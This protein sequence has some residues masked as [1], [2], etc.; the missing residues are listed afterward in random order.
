[1]ESWKVIEAMF[2]ATD[3]NVLRQWRDAG[4]PPVTLTLRTA[5]GAQSE[6]LLAY[7]ESLATHLPAVTIKRRSAD[8]ETD[9]PALVITER[10]HYLATPMG[11]ELAPF[12]KALLDSGRGLPS[13]TS[14]TARGLSA[15]PLPARLE[16]FITPQ[17]PFCPVT[18]ST[19]LPLALA[20]GRQR[21]S[22]IDGT[23]FPD[24]A[25]ARAIRTAPTVILDGSF[26]WTG[27]PGIDEI[28][29]VMVNREPSRLSPDSLRG[30]IEDGMAETVARMMI[31]HG[32]IFDNLLP[33]LAHDKWPVRLGAMVVMESFQTLRPDLAAEA[34]E[35]L[36]SLMET[37]ANPVKGDLLHVIG[38]TGDLRQVARLEA[39]LG[40]GLPP[41]LAEAAADALE[42]IRGRVRPDGR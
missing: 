21:L 42:A 13:L 26:R 8:R 40:E 31:D 29:D 2:A 37:A 23:L 1:M 15:L 9:P 16:V 17:C 27:K 34:P 38:E 19:L 32:G 7:A 24:L 12:L 11:P 6:A 25:A 28:V 33:L 18:V 30:I 35:R 3:L 39:L 10:L 41:D 14:E 5:P 22:V 4:T 36:W 20:P